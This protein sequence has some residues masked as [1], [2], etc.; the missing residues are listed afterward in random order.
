M[1]RSIRYVIGLALLAGSA[2]GLS[3]LVRAR[4]DTVRKARDIS[5][6]IAG[7]DEIISPQE[8]DAF[9]DRIGYDGPALDE[10]DR[11]TFRSG[12]KNIGVYINYSPACGPWILPRHSWKKIFDKDK[13]SSILGVE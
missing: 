9:L 11:L 2:F 5:L 13:L 4:M 3:H 8:R 7:H 12:T 6:K 10:S 1:Y